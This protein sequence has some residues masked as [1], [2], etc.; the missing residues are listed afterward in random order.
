MFE[1]S[2]LSPTDFEHLARDLIQHSDGLNFESFAPGPDS[3]IDFRFADVDGDVIIQAKH[4]ERSGFSNLKS[5]CRTEVEKVRLLTPKRYILI[6]SV[7]MTNTRKKELQEIFGEIPLSSGDIIGREDLQARLEAAPPI[8][9]RH[10]KLWLTSASVLDR[11]LKS[12]VYERT[13]TE[14]DEIKALVPRFVQHRG[15]HEAEDIL[16]E[17]GSLVIS[18]AP[19]VGKTTLARILIWLH[20]EQGWTIKVIDSID[21][22]F[23]AI[24]S[25]DKQLIFFDDFLGQVRLTDDLVRGTDARLPAF[26]RRVVFPP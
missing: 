19:G 17:N 15:V 3:G 24:S 21:E 10:F 4:Y 12:A 5:A 22:V 25:D 20:M 9:R 23:E 14:L 26:L 8:L 18:G 13:N 16:S 6:T 1:F 7:S 11:I 2:N